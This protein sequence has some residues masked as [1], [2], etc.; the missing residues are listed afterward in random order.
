MFLRSRLAVLA[1]I[2]SMTA[3]PAL[4]AVCMDK[5]M[6]QD[7]IIDT[8]NAQSGCG[9]AMKVFQDCEYGAS[10]DVLLG[11]AVEKKCE[12]DFLSG[13]GASQKK[14]YASQ[15]KRCDAKYRNESGTMYRS[16]TAFCRAEVSQRYSQKALKASPKAR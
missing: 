7:E 2:V 5:S 3:S 14:A 12:A 10:G 8:I 1:A 15:L 4:S 16:F 6:T 9:R 13:L 11:A